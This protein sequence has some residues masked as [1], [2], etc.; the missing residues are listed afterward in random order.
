LGSAHAFHVNKTAI[1]NVDVDIQAHLDALGSQ[2]NLSSIVDGCKADFINHYQSSWIDPRNWTIS[3]FHDSAGNIIAAALCC[4]P[5]NPVVLKP[6]QDGNIPDCRPQDVKFVRIQLRLDFARL[7][8]APVVPG[9]LPPVTILSADFYIELPQTT[10]QMLNGNNVAYQ[11]TTWHG[12]DDI[13]T[14][15]PDQVRDNIL[16]PCLCDS[17]LLLATA[18]FNLPGIVRTSSTQINSDVKQKILRLAF[19]QVCHTLFKNL[20]PHYTDQ[21]Y[22]AV[23]VI[24]QSYI[25]AD[26]NRVSSSVWAYHQRMTLAMRPFVSSRVFPVSVYNKFIDGLDPRI[27]PYFN[28][29]YA[30][31]WQ[32]HPL[33][34]AHQKEKLEEIFLAAHSAE[35]QYQR[36]GAT[37]REAVGH[38]VGQAYTTSAYP[39]QA[40]KTL[41]RYDSTSPQFA[42]ARRSKNHNCFGCGSPDH[43]WKTNS[44]VTCPQGHLPAIQQKAK[45]NWKDFK[46]KKADKACSRAKRSLSYADLDDKG[47]KRLAKEVFEAQAPETGSVVSSVTSPPSA[48]LAGPAPSPTQRIHRTLNCSVLPSSNL[49]VM[50]VLNS[51]IAPERRN[52]PVPVLTSLPTIALPIGC[53]TDDSFPAIKCIIDTAAGLSTGNIRYIGSLAK[54]YP[55]TVARIYA[56]SN[57]SPILLSG[58]VSNSKDEA[59]LATTELDCAFEFHLPFYG[60]DGATTSVVLVTG[61]N[62]SVN[63]ILGLPFLKATGGILDLDADVLELRRLECAPFTIQYLRAGCYIPPEDQTSAAAAH[64][65]LDQYKHI[66]DEVENLVS[67]V[68]NK[69]AM[70]PPARSVSFGPTL[71]LEPSRPATSEVNQP[72]TS[73]Q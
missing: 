13:R 34:G 16:W 66:I 56:P 71:E 20:C 49:Q 45:D 11:L 60:R 38:P 27:H 15:T 61:A 12:A 25:D 23:E 64:A 51:G 58:I 65:R 1:T 18:D 44:V 21:P 4:I 14:L 2:L 67:F 37:A 70:P 31:H 5:N 55:H 40:E 42:S 63:S 57:Y 36:M 62:V 68:T 28:D 22:A 41:A 7:M 43:A 50:H 73:I 46:K 32:V 69:V 26:G 30:N 17:P 33:D 48:P 72:P 29:R 19:N 24:K 54:Q 8:T 3:S 35:G 6:I 53:P 39:S 59:Q 52:L 9:D 47:K 10:R